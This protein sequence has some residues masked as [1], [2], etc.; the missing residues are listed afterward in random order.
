MRRKTAAEI[1]NRVADRVAV[2]VRWA[3]GTNRTATRAKREGATVVYQYA[4]KQRD[5]Y[6]LCARTL[7]RGILD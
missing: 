2:F 6:M 3:R 7:K 1:R 4:K 5:A